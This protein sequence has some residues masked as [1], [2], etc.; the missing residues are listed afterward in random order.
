[1]SS[2]ED[3]DRATG[4]HDILAGLPIAFDI[5]FLNV[6]AFASG[7]RIVNSRL[8][9]LGLRVREYS[10]LAVACGEVGATQRQL[11]GM[12][13]LDPSQIVALVDALERTGL[14]R[15]DIDPA[16]RRSRLVR[17]TPEG[18][19]LFDRAREV[20]G[21]AEREALA[22]LTD[23]ERDTLRALLRKIVFSG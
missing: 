15:R 18:R 8:Q 11:A 1:M 13:E 20:A 17:A 21:A 22:M 16:D 12:L 10:V 9:R 3:T 23:A 19:R 4:A 7:T 6:K 5:E 2:A 14:V